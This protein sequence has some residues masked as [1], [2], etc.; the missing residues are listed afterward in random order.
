M[1]SPRNFNLELRTIASTLKAVAF[2]EAARTESIAEASG[3]NIQKAKGMLG[4]LLSAEFIVSST[5]GYQL[6]P[7]GKAVVDGDANFACNGTLWVFYYRLSSNP[8][9]PVWYYLANRF[10]PGRNEFSQDEAL[11]FL[12]ECR[13]TKKTRDGRLVSRGSLDQHLKSDLSLFLRAMTRENSLGSLRYLFVVG[14][15]RDRVD[16]CRYRRVPNPEVEP[17]IVGLVLYHERNRCRPGASTWNVPD[18]LASEGNIG[19]VFGL[20]E[21]RFL[22]YVG[23]LQERRLL[24]FT[25]HADLYQVGFPWQGNP[26]ELLEM[27]Y[28]ERPR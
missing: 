8:D 13:L 7:I 18:L 23:H 17:L 12:L 6:T 15:D 22:H 25:C 11:Q 26:V 2:I 5:T 20:T 9:F 24:T 19:R 10:L 28:K 3:I 4:W 14:D 27:Y 16:L 21:E 1:A